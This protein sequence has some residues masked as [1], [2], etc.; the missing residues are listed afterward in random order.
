[1]NVT[2]SRLLTTSLLLMAAC[3]AP[4]ARPT[5][6]TTGAPS[7][8]ASDANAAPNRDDEDGKRAYVRATGG[9]S[10]LPS[11]D[12]ESGDVGALQQ[13]DAS[14][15]PGFAYTFGAGY[16]VA[17]DW[18]MEVELGYRTNPIDRVRNTGPT[19]TEGDFASLGF[20]ANARY[21][22]PVT[23]SLQPYVGLGLGLLQEIDIDLGGGTEVDYS[24]SALAIQAILGVDYRFSSR[25]ALQLEGRYLQSF[26]QDLAAESG[27]G[28]TYD[29]DYQ[30]FSVLLGL[31]WS[32]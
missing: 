32:F 2:H 12:L 8:T 29:A 15:D 30:P 20:F 21:H 3:T 22:L 11:T 23:G 14:F 4:G 31:S 18:S 19:I 1:M 10:L 6:A 9:L 7:S 17:D 27:S 16:R 5:W 13:A 28:I 24:D 26:G 25:W